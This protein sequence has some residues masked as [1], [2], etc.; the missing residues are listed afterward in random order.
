MA[1]VGGT[2]CGEMLIIMWTDDT[3][4]AVRPDFSDGGL[5]DF[6]ISLEPHPAYGSSQLWWPA[7]LIELGIVTEAEVKESD[8]K[9]KAAAAKQKEAQERALLER[10]KAVYDSPPSS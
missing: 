4:S 6:D 2:E 3:F 7:K 10:L 9:A 5:I 1:K 8:E